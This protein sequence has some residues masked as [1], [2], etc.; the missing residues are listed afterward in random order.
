MKLPIIFINFLLLSL[1][2]ITLHAQ[3]DALK[4]RAELTNYEETSRYADVMSFIKALQKNT[5]NLRVESFGKSEEKRDLPLLIFSNPAIS[6]PSDAKKSGKP[7]VFIMANIHAGEVDGKEALL[8]LSRRIATGDLKPLLDKLIILIAPIYNAD[9]NERIAY[10]HRP[11]Q[12]GPIG[13]VG[14]RPNAK[15]LNLNRDYMKLDSSEAK[16]LVR[17]MNRWDPALTVDLHTTNGSYHGY[18]LTY[19]PTLHPN[20]DARL[21]AFEREKMLPIINKNM[22][23]RHKFRTYYYG[24]FSYR[25]NIVPNNKSQFAE[26]GPELGNKEQHKLFESE[27]TQFPNI[28]SELDTGKTKIWRTFSH[29][30]RFGNNYVGLRNR[31]ALLSE[32]YSYLDFKDRVAATA[33]FVEEILKYSAAHAKEI[34]N[35]V[36]QV[37]QDTMQL[38]NKTKPAQLGVEFTLTPLPEPVN[39]LIGTVEKKKNPRSDKDMLAMVENKFSTLR[40]LDYGVISPTENAELPYA[41]I[42]RSEPGLRSLL[43]KLLAHGIAVEQTTE[44]LTTEV[45]QFVIDTAKKSAEKTEGH[46]EMSVTGHLATKKMT[47]PAGSI[48]VRTTQPLARLAFSLLEVKSDDSLAAWNFMDPYLAKGK[49][50]PIYKLMKPAIFVSQAMPN[51]IN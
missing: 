50:Y 18:H 49:V 1:L 39:I 22:L 41:Y 16:A 10:D 40:M 26:I 21:I 29:N 8:H 14:T 38:S 36:K 11:E 32:S 17:L 2:P 43:N 3:I 12:N 7:V 30:A 27:L 19:S 25:E 24:N 13:G 4:S 34:V 15:G 37:D 5:N 9:G 23:T 35:L 31:L 51:P 45:E 42:F 44:P 48:I 28:P 46:H 20:T 6:Q 33:A 47:F